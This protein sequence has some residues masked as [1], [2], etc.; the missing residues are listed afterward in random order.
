MLADTVAV[1]ATGETPEGPSLDPDDIN[2][3]LAEV[4]VEL[5][6]EAR[7]R[8]PSAAERARRPVGPAKPARQWPLR[9]LRGRRTAAYVRKPVA[10]PGPPG[11]P[12]RRGQPPRGQPPRGQPARE[13]SRPVPD[14]GYATS[15]ARSA[16]GR[17]LAVIAI[18]VV[19]AAVLLSLLNRG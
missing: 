1:A 9:W 7:F 3:R 15:S 14:R 2:N 11:R 12:G 17:T 6:A 19:V 10:G 8:E 5:A 18:A 4:A 16:P 13:R